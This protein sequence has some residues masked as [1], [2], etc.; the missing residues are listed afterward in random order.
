M[1]LRLLSRQIHERYVTEKALSEPEISGFF[2]SYDD[3]VI[4]LSPSSWVS[5]DMGQPNM[6]FFGGRLSTETG[7]L[8]PLDNS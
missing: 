8:F 3:V 4:R 6:Q 7:Y 5:W 2:A 1:R